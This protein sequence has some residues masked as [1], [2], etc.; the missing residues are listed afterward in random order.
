VLALPLPAGDDFTP[1][2]GF[3]SL[4]DGKDVSGWST[5]EAGTRSR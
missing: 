3:T 2:E 5:S 1:E 4:F